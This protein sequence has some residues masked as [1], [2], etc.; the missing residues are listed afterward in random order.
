MKKHSELKGAKMRELF[1]KGKRV[2]NREWVV[3]DLIQLHDGRR[4]IVNNLHGA[5]IDD[6]GNF[7]N[8]E[9]P[10]VCE[11]IPETVGQYTGLTDKNGKEI[12]EGDIVRVKFKGFRRGD[13]E[14]EYNYIVQY[15]EY[16]ACWKL[17]GNYDL[18]GSPLCCQGNQHLMEVIGNIHDISEILEGE[19]NA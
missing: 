18:L 14:K 11:V 6:K 8:T 1:F 10:F 7:I 15:D 19:T 2:D 13:V 16:E 4:Y 9:Y 5:C 3:G 17:D 12:F